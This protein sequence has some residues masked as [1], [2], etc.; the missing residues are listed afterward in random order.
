MANVAELLV[1]KLIENAVDC[2]CG[3]QGDSLNAV[4]DAIR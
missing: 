4:T 3:L 1:D 2:V